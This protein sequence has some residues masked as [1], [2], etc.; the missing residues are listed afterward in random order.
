MANS[1]GTH[2]RGQNTIHSYLKKL[3]NG[4]RHAL[5]VDCRIWKIDKHFR[6]LGLRRLQLPTLALL[7]HLRRLLAILRIGLVPLL[8]PHMGWLGSID[9]LFP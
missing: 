9:H 6:G 1:Y 8:H 3:E 5:T 4:L 7:C 2:A